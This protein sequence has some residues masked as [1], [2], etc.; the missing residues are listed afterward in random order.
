MCEIRL[1]YRLRGRS[2]SGNDADLCGIAELRKELFAV[3]P[4]GAECANVGD[5]DPRH[6]VANGRKMSCIEFAAHQC[7]FSLVYQAVQRQF[8]VQI[9]EEF[10]SN[11]LA[12]NEHQM[13]SHYA[14]GRRLTR[15][16]ERLGR[17]DFSVNRPVANLCNTLAMSV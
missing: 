8:M 16:F 4:G 7:G 1:H 10:L 9:C 11:S 15:P 14:A 6:N 17:D 2:L 5:A 3:F 13:Y 12:G